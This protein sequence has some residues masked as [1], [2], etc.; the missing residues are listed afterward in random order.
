MGRAIA[1]FVLALGG[2]VGWA[3]SSLYQWVYDLY[4]LGPGFRAHAV[5]NGTG[6]EA[7]G[8]VVELSGPPGRVEWLVLGGQLDLGD[9]ASERVRLA[10]RVVSGGVAALALPEG[11]RPLRV[12][13]ITLAGEVPVDVES[14][15]PRVRTEDLSL[16]L[17]D[18]VAEDTS[19]A[20]ASADDGGAFEFAPGNW[21]LPKQQTGDPDRPARKTEQEARP[22]GGFIWLFELAEWSEWLTYPYLVRVS[23]KDSFS[24]LGE[25]IV[26]WTW[27][28][29]DGV[30]QVGP[31]VVRGFDRPGWHRFTLVVRHAAGREQSLRWFV[32]VSPLAGEQSESENLHTK[33]M[34]KE[35]QR[36]VVEPKIKDPVEEAPM[37]EG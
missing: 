26:S 9:L 32:V 37:L 2:V 10:G 14:P 31:E 15:I 7:V 33:P 28:W 5:A 19:R 6:A 3:Q 23:A 36:E 27:L 17:L 13:W 34:E 16:A 24:P 20:D 11:L 8:L 18:G 25:E 29:E 22:R 12:A 35:P 30:V 1:V 21:D 4:A